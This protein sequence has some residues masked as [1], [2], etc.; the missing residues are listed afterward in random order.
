M[1]TIVVWLV[2]SVVAIGCSASQPKKTG[3]AGM[4]MDV[5][6]PTMSAPVPQYA[7]QPM[8]PVVYDGPSQP[9]APAALGEPAEAEIAALEPGARQYTVKRGDTLWKI[10]EMQ[11]GHGNRWQKIAMANPGLSPERLQA[12]QKIRLP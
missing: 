9:M 12:G 1:K 7:P 6:A 11:Y 5:T 10:A 4:V 3:A 8:Q 2:L